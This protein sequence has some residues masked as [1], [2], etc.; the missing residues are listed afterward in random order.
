MRPYSVAFVENRLHMPVKGEDFGFDSDLFHEF[1][2]KRDGKRLPHLDP[3]AGEREMAD[4]RR[5]RPADDENPAVSKHRRRDREN[6][7][8]GKEPVV[9]E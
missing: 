5:S 9:H 4:E 3:P 1:A 8:S 6:R 7:A 2:S